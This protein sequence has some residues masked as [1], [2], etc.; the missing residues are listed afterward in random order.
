VN[1]G[2]I[3]EEELRKIAGSTGFYRVLPKEKILGLT[4][5]EVTDNDIV[6]EAYN[7]K[8]N[9]AFF[10]S[11]QVTM[12]DPINTDWSLQWPIGFPFVGLAGRRE[13]DKT[14]VGFSGNPLGKQAFHYARVDRQLKYSGKSE[15]F[16][17]SKNNDFLKA[18]Q[19]G[20]YYVKRFIDNHKKDR[21]PPHA[22]AVCVVVTKQPLKGEVALISAPTSE[23]AFSSS[24]FEKVVTLD[25]AEV[26][27][28]CTV[29]LL[30][31]T[32]FEKF[33][34]TGIPA[35]TEVQGA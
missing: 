17:N 4:K 5:P 13:G 12:Q 32:S 15:D 34:K 24:V 20:A 8:T 28:I 2:E 35:I 21:R 33:L 22:L 10:L 27:R 11:I 6:L 7:R 3:F 26:P 29:I 9:V 30:N 18:M 25:Y 23:A 19:V 31:E 14:V 1:A 16:L